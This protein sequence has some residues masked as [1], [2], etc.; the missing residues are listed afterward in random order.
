VKDYLSMQKRYRH[1]T[2]QELDEVQ[3]TVDRD[4]ARLVQRCEAH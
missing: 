1:L 2:A 3:A 4:W